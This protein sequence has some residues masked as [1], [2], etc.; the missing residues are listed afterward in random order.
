MQDLI[1]SFNDIREK[2]KRFTK[3]RNRKE[4][5]PYSVFHSDWEAVGN[6]MRKVFEGINKEWEALA[7][8]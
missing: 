7:N 1:P 5:Q 6:D 8:E 4:I 3:P 2:I